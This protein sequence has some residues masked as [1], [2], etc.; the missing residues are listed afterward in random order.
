MRIGIVGTG[1]MGAGLARRLAKAGLQTAIAAREPGKAQA[2]VAKLGPGAISCRPADLARHA[3]IIVL[4]LP[5][6]AMPQALASLGDL[7]GKV[8]VDISNP[9]TPDY[10]ALTVGHT[11]SAAEEIQKLAPGARVVKAFNTVFAELLDEPAPVQVFYAADDEA[12][13]EQVAELIGYC[14]FEPVNAGALSNSR[15]LEPV[16]ELNIHLG[17]ALGWGTKIAPAWQ[18]VA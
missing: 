12:A 17:Y 5:Y 14:G 4:A 7:K 2:L 8:L 9:V 15:Y 6:G 18:R 1:R 16:G 10:L 13:A 3:G 11:S